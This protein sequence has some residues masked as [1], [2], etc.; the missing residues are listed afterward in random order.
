MP[1]GYGCVFTGVG[2]ASGPGVR[3]TTTPISTGTPADEH[4]A[5]LRVKNAKLRRSIVALVEEAAIRNAIDRSEDAA[6]GSDIG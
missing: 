1:A 4:D 5:F 6:V 3:S 2:N